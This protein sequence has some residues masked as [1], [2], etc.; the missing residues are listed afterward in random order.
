MVS[1]RDLRNFGGQVLD[2]V[3]RGET[4]TVTRDGE[5]IAQVVPLPRNTA[6]LSVLI[7]RRRSL[8]P[9]DTNALRADVD[10][11]MDPSL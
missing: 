1:V 11:F 8:P 2:R 7:E 6:P 3:S 10:E 9:V 4:L 5:P